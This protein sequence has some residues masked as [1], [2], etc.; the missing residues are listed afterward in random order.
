M[1]CWLALDD[2]DESNGCLWVVP[3]SHRSG[4][5]GHHGDGDSPF[6][7]GYDGDEPG[8]AAPVP[9]GG[10]LVISS[11][12]LHRSGP[13]TTGRLRRAWVIQFCPAQACSALSGNLVV[14][15]AGPPARDRP[16]GFLANYDKR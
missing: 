8:V 13:N 2:A 11:L 16:R 7:V 3:G 5:M 4:T 15:G 6:R 14:G 10:V 9:K 12:L 1:T